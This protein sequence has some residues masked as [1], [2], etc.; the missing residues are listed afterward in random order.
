[1]G[2]VQKFLLLASSR[3]IDRIVRINLLHLLWH[4]IKH[5]TERLHASAE[6]LLQMDPWIHG[7]NDVRRGDRMEISFVHGEEK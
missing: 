3:P 2:G 5:L 6:S 7:W 1:M 4:Y